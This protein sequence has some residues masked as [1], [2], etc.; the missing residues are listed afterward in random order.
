MFGD[1]N[2]KE[3]YPKREFDESKYQ[4]YKIPTILEKNKERDFD[5]LRLVQDFQAH[6]NTILVAEFSANWEFLATGCKEGYLK[7]WKIYGIEYDDEPYSLVDKE[8]YAV[9]YLEDEDTE[10]S[11]LDISW[12]IKEPKIIVTGQ[13]NCKSILWDIEKSEAPLKVFIHQDAVSWVSFHPESESPKLIFLTGCLDK[14]YQVW[15]Q[16]EEK[17]IYS[18]QAKDHVTALAISPDGIRVVIGLHTGQLIVCGY[19]NTKLNY[20]TAIECKNRMGKY[21]KGTKITSIVFLDNTSVLVT[22]NDSRIRIVNVEGRLVGSGTKQMKFKGHLN[23]NL[24]IKASLSEDMD[25][26]IWGSEDGYVYIW[27]RFH[28]DEDNKFEVERNASREKFAPFAPEMTIPTVSMFAP[29]NIQRMFM[30]KYSI[31]GIQKVLKN[32]ILVTGFD[33]LIRVFHNTFST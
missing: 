21:S 2:D 25:Y 4:T 11:I 32:M 17:P 7:I 27:N 26:I 18:L 9:M 12:W 33:G 23:D 29:L 16:D 19:D 22:T 8:H 15:S 30:S 6:S 1:Q 3:N 31:W 13:I 20:I 5:D 28:N 14:T 24:Q 10:P